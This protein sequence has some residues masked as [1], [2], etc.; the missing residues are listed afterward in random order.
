[1]K[2]AINHRTWYAYGESAPVCHN[3]LHLA[4]R[5]TPRQTCREHRLEI[6]PAPAFSTQRLDYFGNLCDYFSIESSH[7]GLEINS[8]SVVEVAPRNT[9]ANAESP[10]W[11][12]IAKLAREGRGV[13]AGPANDRDGNDGGHNTDPAESSDALDVYLLTLPSPRVAILPELRAYAASSF[14]TGRPVLAGIIE[15]TARIHADFAF[16]AKA[17]TV[18]TPLQ[19]LMRLRRGVCQD[20][21]HLGVGCLRALGLPARYVSGYLRTIPPPGKPRM[22]GA[23]AS[24]AWLSAWC[25]PLGWID[26]DP[27]N[28]TLVGDSH[29]TI[30]WG[31]DY[32]DVCPIQGVFVGGGEHSMGVSVDVVPQE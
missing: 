12:D 22:V 31:R 4:P 15:L 16:D 32:G 29:I 8:T 20:F 30:A 14:P 9:N 1:M 11:E 21:A 5:S 3:L 2:Y 28:N 26:F 18:H 24:H 23:D 19:E 7:A 13:S 17:T 27:T 25:G 10:A 6:E